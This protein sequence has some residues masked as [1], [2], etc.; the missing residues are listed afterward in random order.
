MKHLVML[1]AGDTHLHLLSTWVAQPLASVQI[2]LVSPYPAHFHPDMAAGYV[3]GHTPL[4]DC[5]IKLAGLLDG[6]GVN[7]LQRNAAALDSA[8]RRLTLDDGSTLEFDVLSINPGPQYDRQ[9]IEQ[10]MPGARE[11]ALF[12]YPCEAL[13]RLW[14]Q[15]LAF[16]ENRALRVA[17]IGA[18]KTAVELA[19]AVAQRLKGSSVTL[20]TGNAPVVSGYPPAVQ[21]R[22]LRALKDRQVTLISE[23]VCGIAAG[24]VNLGHDAQLTCDVPIIAID[25][26]PPA[27]LPCSGLALDEKGFV[28]RDAFWRASSHPDVFAAADVSTRRD[29]QALGKNLRAVLAGAVPGTRTSRQKPMRFVTCGDL[30]AIACWGNLSAQGRWVEWLKHRIDQ[31]FVQQHRQPAGR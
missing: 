8:A 30:S 15:V 22:V 31:G 9:S 19:L 2:T 16:A 23:P 24:V 28:M 10:T 17:V 12:A 18:G 6:S 27:W 5:T 25:A 21:A 1:G 11:H 20:L 4:E 7:W 26:Q 14:P 3:A 29:R 13:G